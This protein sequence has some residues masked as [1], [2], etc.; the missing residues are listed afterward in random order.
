MAK[1]VALIPEEFISSYHHF[2]KPDKRLEDEIGLLL[3]KANLADDMKVKLLSQLIMRYHQAV[4]KV[5]DP[6]RVTVTN[7][8]VTNDSEKT[9]TKL[10]E[11]LSDGGDDPIVKEIMQSTPHRYSKYVPLII[12]KLKSR[13]YGWNEWNEMTDNNKAIPYSNI[14]DFFVY[15]MRN[16]KSL[17]EPKH[18]HHFL[19]ALKEIR[20]PHAWIE[21]SHFYFA[22]GFMYFK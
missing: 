17:V 4:H 1:R 22:F 5:P 11:V 13:Q 19:R 20:I 9:E 16:A 10:S 6:V 12:E 2:L 7:D 3:E 21:I 15:L 18:F 14:I 8:P